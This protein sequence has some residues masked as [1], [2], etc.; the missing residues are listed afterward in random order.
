[1]KKYKVVTQLV[2]YVWADSPEDA[3][4]FHH[5]RIRRGELS[6]EKH[7]TQDTRP[8][9]A[10][11]V[12]FLEAPEDISC[13]RNPVENPRPRDWIEITQD[14]MSLVALVTKLSK[15]KVYYY[16]A[17]T[18]SERSID[19]EK[20]AKWASNHPVH[21]SYEQKLP[22]FIFKEC[23]R[24]HEEKGLITEQ[25][26]TPDS[27]VILAM[28]EEYGYEPDDYELRN[29]YWAENY[30]DRELTQHIMENSIGAKTSGQNK[31]ESSDPWDISLGSDLPT[32]D[33]LE[34]ATATR[35][36]NEHLR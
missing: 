34:Q 29:G 10:L 24:A 3:T 20:W 13:T 33:D 4:K 23:L 22:A 31:P 25:G 21:A 27:S 1:M 5:E 6:L 16:E 28:L 12:Q 17:L 14:G 35:P 26:G 19:R 32:L 8:S 36:Q 9:R 2:S 15:R 7:A 18:G 11:G 30:L